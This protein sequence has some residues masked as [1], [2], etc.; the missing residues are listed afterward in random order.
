[1][2]RLGDSHTAKRCDGFVLLDSNLIGLGRAA[3]KSGVIRKAE[4]KL[5]FHITPAIWLRAPFA[6]FFAK[7][8]SK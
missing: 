2:G 8:G 1:M 5:R 3:T 4:E 7:P 6:R